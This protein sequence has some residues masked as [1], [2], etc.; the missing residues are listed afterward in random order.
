MLFFAGS[1]AAIVLATLVLNRSN[2]SQRQNAL[3]HG[4]I[5]CGEFGHHVFD[6]SQCHQLR[7]IEQQHI[8]AGEFVGL[9]QILALQNRL[10]G[11]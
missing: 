7:A 6:S 1:I 10:S 11:T 2:G 9:A 8:S 3:K 5:R 4:T